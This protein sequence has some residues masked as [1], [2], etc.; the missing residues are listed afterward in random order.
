MSDYER[1]HAVRVCRERC[2]EA[3]YWGEGFDECVKA[4]IEELRSHS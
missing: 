4:C 2:A 1:A 3:G